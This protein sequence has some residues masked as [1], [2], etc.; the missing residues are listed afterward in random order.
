MYSTTGD[1]IN[2]VIEV[3]Q[4]IR[5]LLVMKVIW[6]LPDIQVLSDL[7]ECKVSKD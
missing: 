3:F 2:P 4:V 1:Q 7:K 5:E 6:D